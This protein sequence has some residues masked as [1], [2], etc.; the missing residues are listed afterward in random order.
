M[1]DELSLAQRV[2]ALSDEE[3]SAVL[4]GISEEKLLWDWRFWGR[5]AQLLPQDD[6]WYLALMLAG[7]GFGK[8]LALETPIPTP[9]G[10]TTMGAL[11]DGD[12]VLDERGVPCRV[13][14]AHDVE[15]PAS[16]YRLTFSDGTSIEAGEEH[17]WVTWTHRERKQY[18]RK[19]RATDFPEDWARRVPVRTTQDLVDT[20]THS[21][22]G[23]RN[24][25]I[26][27]AGSLRLPEADLPVDPWL[28][29]F[30][31]G[32]GSSASGELTTG[33]ADVEWVLARLADRVAVTYSR[34]ERTAWRIGTKG[35]TPRLRALGV[36]NN[37]H[38]PLQ[39]LRA[40][41]QQRL[42]L[43]RGLMDS[44]GHIH[45][46]NGCAEFSGMND[47]LV[48]G[49]LELVRSLSEKPVLSEGRASLRGRD[50]GPKYRV[51]WRPSAHA[52]VA[53]P[54]KAS[55]LR[56]QGAQG[57][58]NRHRMLIAFEEIVPVPMRCITVDSPHAMYL[59]GDG[60]IPTHNT[61]GS[62][63]WVREKAMRMPG[64]R[65]ALVARTAA[66]VRDVLVQGES[67]VLAISPPSERPEYEPLKRRLVW[68]NGTVATLFTADA[69]DQLR[70]PQ[71]HWS[72]CDELA[73]WNPTP[74]ASGLT[75][76]DNVRI[77]TRLGEHPQIVAATTPKRTPIIK[78]LLAL[79]ETDPGVI[80]R[81][82]K[83]SDNAGN[84]AQSYLDTIY[85][86]YEGTSLAQQELEGI[87]LDS[88]EGA[89]WSEEVI[90]PMRVK[91]VPPNLA[92]VVGVDPSVA[93]NPK[94]E[95]GIV[96]VGVTRT[97]EYHNRRAYVLDD[98][99]VH[100]SPEVWAKQVIHAA[101]KWSAPVIA[102]RNQGDGLITLALRNI[103]PTVRVH[104]VRASVGKSLRA[105]PIAL[106]YEQGRVHHAGFFPDLESQM[107]T[108]VPGETKKSPDRVDA[109]VHALTALMVAAPSGLHLGG[110]SR[111]NASQ[112]TSA[113]LPVSRKGNPGGGR[114]R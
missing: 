92:V 8:L 103:D 37:K 38:I 63:E 100:G 83:T 20:F 12:A 75:A 77:S 26:P 99:S 36:L 106:A 110:R 5:P 108:W 39:Y 85:G 58:R 73:T 109:L 28:L 31:L 67:G 48:G 76:W 61:R 21:A 42:E 89:M 86:L 22:R 49:V 82:G 107:L 91:E 79:A 7:R 72:L 84:L 27:L 23:D 112:L 33:D 18:L 104:G 45:R 30:W 24:H 64:S 52:P 81:R 55:A 111:T 2:A 1:T 96:V 29:G 90:E 16:A 65:G 51:T 66:D 78:E 62:C 34:R 13:L 98:L 50:M 43:L 3:R 80:L 46:E 14:K 114:R 87:F 105:E 113:R 56:Q 19:S 10:W 60:M 15:T 57:L 4:A 101:R 68:P 6:S 9:T 88:I 95:C 44:D 54:R 32:D 40:S 102:E 94:D 69:P 59:A 53:L 74:D 11:R 25:C 70:G 41:E 93:E 47:L 97:R 71:Q 17:Q 35:L